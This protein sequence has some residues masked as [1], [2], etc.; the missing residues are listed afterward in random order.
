MA[1]SDMAIA[2]PEA[3]HN[4][5]E[6]TPEGL[7]AMLESDG[8]SLVHVGGRQHRAIALLQSLGRVMPQ[9]TGR[10]EHEVTYRPGSDERSYS[11]SANTI[12][13]HTE[14]PGWQ[15]T[16]RYIAL[17]CQ[18]QAR[19]GGGHT[20]LLDGA[21][22]LDLLGREEYELFSTAQVKFPGP[23]FA[24][25]EHDFVRTPMLAAENGRPVLRFSY[26]LLVSGEYDPEL[27]GR[28]PPHLLPLGARGMHLAGVVSELFAEHRIPL[29]IPDGAMLVWDN[30]RM[31]H[32]R[33]EYR[34][35][36]RHL[37]RYWI[38]R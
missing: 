20:D 6:P 28:R 25:D 15:P 24:E 5:G 22:L 35:P 32:A 30:H 23:R 27:S 34:D 10:L 38:G 7:R 13:A 11:Q 14:A 3:L 19:C 4:A 17:Y 18:R 37:T 2:T 33:S 36:G 16:P 29:L 1:M 12:L 8:Y 21:K 9:Y 31:L 26:N